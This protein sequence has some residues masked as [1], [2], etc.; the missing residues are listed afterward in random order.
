MFGLAEYAAAWLRAHRFLPGFG[1]FAS[2][3]WHSA[4]GLVS[5]LIYYFGFSFRRVISGSKKFPEMETMP[6]TYNNFPLRQGQPLS[7][8]L[9]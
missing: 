9:A 2:Q 3:L 7:F 4:T 1:D 6:S 5:L 8:L